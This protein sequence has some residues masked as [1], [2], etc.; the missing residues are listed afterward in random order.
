MVRLPHSLEKKLPCLR[1][2][3]LQHQSNEAQRSWARF[4]NPR[5][6]S[7]VDLRPNVA[8]PD[9]CG[10]CRICRINHSSLE[11]DRMGLFRIQIMRYPNLPISGWRVERVKA[12][13]EALIMPF[14]LEKWYKVVNGREG[15]HLTA[16]R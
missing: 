7:A 8:S 11:V 9:W 3:S 12:D 14:A 16:L 15:C 10:T 13:H 5:C 4:T 1:F 2:R 6:G